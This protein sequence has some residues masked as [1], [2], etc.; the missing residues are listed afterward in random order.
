[1]AQLVVRNIDDDLK[2]RLKRRAAQHGRSM[3]AEVRDILRAAVKP[4]DQ[5]PGGLGTQIAA[6]FEGIGFTDEEV[7]AIEDLRTHPFI[8]VSFDE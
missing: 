7:A 6:L 4:E 3:E 1:M 5:P 8:P 2:A